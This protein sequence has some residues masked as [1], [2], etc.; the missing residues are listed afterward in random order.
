MKNGENG[1]KQSSV[2]LFRLMLKKVGRKLALRLI[3]LQRDKNSV[4]RRVEA[5]AVVLD[6][7]ILLFLA[8]FDPKET[9]D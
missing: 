7:R 8:C 9:R 2:V 6:I 5:E 3:D 4:L 1:M